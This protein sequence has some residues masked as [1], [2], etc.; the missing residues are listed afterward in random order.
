MIR[1]ITNRPA[2]LMILGLIIVGGVIQYERLDVT[3]F[4]SVDQPVITFGIWRTSMSSEEFIERF[5]DQLDAL[6]Q[7]IPDTTLTQFTAAQGYVRGEV[8]FPHGYD[9]QEAEQLVSSVLSG[10]SG[11]LPNYMREPR[12]RRDRTGRDGSMY[13]LLEPHDTSAQNVL[14]LMTAMEGELGSLMEDAE[15]GVESFYVSDPWEQEVRIHPELEKVYATGLTLPDLI[16]QIDRARLDETVGEL[17]YERATLHVMRR[18]ENPAQL[19]QLPI[20]APD[21][22]ELKLSDVARVEVATYQDNFITLINGE[23]AIMLGVEPKPDANLVRFSDAVRAKAEEIR[24][25]YQDKADFHIQT[26][27]GSYITSAIS[28]VLLAVFIAVGLSAIVVLLFFGRP[29]LGLITALSIPLSGFAAI[30]LLPIFDVSIN[31]L[32]LGSMALAVGMVIDGAVVVMENALYHLRSQ[33]PESSRARAKVIL[34]AVKEVALPVLGGTVT[35]I[36]VFLPLTLTAPMA[37]ALLGDIA[38]VVALTLGLAIPVSLGLIPTLVWIFATPKATEEPNP[39][40]K[41]WWSHPYF[42]FQSFYRWVERVYL[43]I[44]SAVLP[45]ARQSARFFVISVLILTGVTGTFAVLFLEQEIVAQPTTNR[46]LVDVTSDIDMD[47][48]LWKAQLVM[49]ESRLRDTLGDKVSSVHSR[50]RDRRLYGGDI[51]A[52]TTVTL[53]EPITEKEAR[54]QLRKVL[55]STARFQL[56]FRLWNPSGL[57]FPDPPHLVLTFT[58]ADGRVILQGLNELNER[59]TALYGDTLRLEPDPW[60][61]AQR[62]LDVEARP[63]LQ[64]RTFWGLNELPTFDQARDYLGQIATLDRIEDFDIDVNGRRVPVKINLPP[65][66]LDSREQLDN[67][68]WSQGQTFVPIRQILNFVPGRT[69]GVLRSRQGEVMMSLNVWVDESLGLPIPEA[70]EQILAEATSMGGAL[71][72]SLRPS[73]P[74]TIIQENVASVA[75]AF[76]AVVLLILLVLTIQFA[77]FRHAFYAMLPIFLGI[78]GV[79]VSLLIAGSTL[80]VNSMLGILLVAGTSVNNSILFIDF[81]RR[82]TR[83]QPDLDPIEALLETARRRL[84]PIMITTLTTVLGMVPLILAIGD[85]GAV[86][87]PLGISVAGGLLC[88]TLLTLVILPTMLASAALRRRGK[89]E[90]SN[91]AEGAAAQA[92]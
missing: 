11:F 90:T 2:V 92:A 73:T 88:S 53:K 3:L 23:P 36:V 91:P 22:R 89:D 1:W 66:L 31:L 64:N 46:V 81:H 63:A 20:L 7:S 82:L 58:G 87:Q 68:L 72:L 78:L 13:I 34:E 60:S 79:S 52:T 27:P 84:R 50:I 9:G 70:S 45:H 6:L 16:A 10:A 19:R 65:D 32:S 86:M 21:G 37:S 49:Q 55:P 77:T 24:E 28:S 43:K 4:P 39:E 85:G 44:L 15:L 25:R 57:E 29:R 59:L 51:D 8:R 26:D 5:G 40:R 12:V 74:Y 35:T 42:G 56:E 80:S 30:I 48:E 62:I 38:L 18:P 71:G 14:D 54:D 76:F 17:N 75:F 61:R 69:E 33:R 83:N 67:L 41:P 47:V